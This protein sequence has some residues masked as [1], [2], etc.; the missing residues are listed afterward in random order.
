MINIYK[1]TNIVNNKIYIGQTTRKIELRF[2]DHISHAF[3]SK[4]KNDLNVKLYKAMREFGI[5][6]F[7]ISLLESID[8]TVKDGDAAEIKW[9]EKL[10]AT[11]DE[12][13]YNT[14]KGGH[15]ISD[16]CRQARIQQMIG[17]TLNENQLEIVRANGMKIAKTICLFDINSGEFLGE[18]ESIMAASK[19]LKCDRRSIQRCLNGE[20]LH[21]LIKSINKD[22]VWRY[23]EENVDRLSEE[24]IQD[25]KQKIFNKRYHANVNKSKS[26]EGIGR[27]VL[28]CDING[29]IIAKYNTAKDAADAIGVN[30]NSIYKHINKIYKSF[31]W[32]FE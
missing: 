12:K 18:Y 11:D 29:N 5:D 14:D 16:K 7:K 20:Y 10:N 31:L 24:D 30:R 9:I 21:C 22:C 25:I 15:T 27:T 28:Q 2:S 8:G 17:S 23:K 19:I 13:G 6:K 32:K 3:N 4:R 1:I 26:H